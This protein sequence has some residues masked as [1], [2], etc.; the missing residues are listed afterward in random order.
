MIGMSHDENARPDNGQSRL[1]AIAAELAN[2]NERLRGVVASLLNDKGSV[3]YPAQHERV[4]AA[5]KALDGPA[6]P[7]S[8][9]TNE[10]RQAAWT[11]FT[12][13]DVPYS[14]IYAVMHACAVPEGTR[15]IL[16][17]YDMRAEMDGD[18]ELFGGPVWI[19]T[20]DADGE[21]V[22]WADIAAQYGPSQAKP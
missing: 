9:I 12:S 16:K 17:R 6:V 3:Q 15:T 7:L 2:E 21:W 10:M 14:A 18:P 4:V 8:D 22:K 20:E 1:I 19:P 13:A 5:R 11:K